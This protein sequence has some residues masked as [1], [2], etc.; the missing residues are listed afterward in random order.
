MRNLKTSLPVQ[1]S[2]E[3]RRFHE[4]D[5]M[6]GIAALVVLFTH[7][8]NM[9][10]PSVSFNHGWRILVYSLV[11]GRESVMF[12]FLL[13]GFVLSL[14][15]LR[16]KGQRYSVFIRRR[17]LR[18]YGP[19]IGALVLALAGC[20]MFHNQVGTTVWASGTWY[21]PVS[22]DSVVQHVLFIGNY[23]YAQ[24]NTAFWSLVYEM[25][26]SIIFPLL[27]LVA[28]KLRT[29]YVLLVIASLTLLGVHPGSHKY[30]ITLEYAGV[31][32]IGALLA[33]KFDVLSARYLS[34]T[35]AQRV[36]LGLTS[37]LLYSYGH[38]LVNIGPLWHLRD[39]PIAVGAAGFIVIGVNSSVASRILNSMVPAFLGRISYSFYLVHG[40][41]LFAMS[42]M[43][44]DRVSHPIFFLL[45]FPTAIFLSWGFYV[46][47]ERPFMLWSR[48]VGRHKAVPGPIR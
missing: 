23:D 1:N 32:L 34:L 35:T 24:Y 16:G 47:V 7:F 27:F 39:M 43:L 20:A 19:Y 12:F 44:L 48:S 38:H 41:I 5:S 8:R 15:L 46:A 40:T 30:L 11:S 4:L 37:Y 17:V 13:S 10:Y 22:F 3:G 25:R 26:I 31:F 29:R 9:A 42:A 2:E 33:K 36:A 45:Y 28:Y 18:I 21:A 6:R 14:P